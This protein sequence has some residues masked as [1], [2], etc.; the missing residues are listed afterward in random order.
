MENLP[1]V[2]AAVV[3]IRADGSEIEGH[4]YGTPPPPDCIGGVVVI[5]EVGTE[6]EESY[7]AVPHRD[8]D[9][10]VRPNLGVFGTYDEAAAVL[11][12]AA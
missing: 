6:D 12:A 11:T 4:V 10:H 9:T 5:R 8:G 1:E 2:E 7:V 3:L